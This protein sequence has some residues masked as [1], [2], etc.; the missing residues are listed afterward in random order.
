[1]LGDEREAFAVWKTHAGKHP[2]VWTSSTLTCSIQ[3]R[4]SDDLDLLALGMPREREREE[5]RA[6]D[7]RMFVIAERR[8][9][10]ES[11][12][13]VASETPEWQGAHLADLMLLQELEL[14]WPSGNGSCFALPLIFVKKE[15]HVTLEQ[16]RRRK[17]NIPG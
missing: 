1:M 14:F 10:S 13:N 2:N 8:R 12:S 4:D 6:K 9:I 3:T 5:M 15:S 17:K 16:W 7:D 11:K